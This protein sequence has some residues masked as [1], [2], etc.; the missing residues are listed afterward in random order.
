MSVR[1][2]K[3][4]KFSTKS[5]QIVFKNHQLNLLFSE[6]KEGFK[7][8][9]ALAGRIKDTE[10]IVETKHVQITYQ[11][12][13]DHFSAAEKGAAKTFF[14]AMER[15]IAAKDEELNGESHDDSDVFA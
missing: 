13:L 2:T 5:E 4:T 9:C 7:A 8:N 6:A 11:D 12:I 1:K 10:G 14:K 3:E 15:T